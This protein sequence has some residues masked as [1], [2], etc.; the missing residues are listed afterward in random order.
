MKDSEVYTPAEDFDS[1]RDPVLFGPL[2]W[3]QRQVRPFTTRELA[4]ACHVHP[5]T[6]RK[7]FRSEPGV[8]ILGHGRLRIPYHV[9]RRVIERLVGGG[10][11]AA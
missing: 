11:A 7:W 5:A 8:L 6:I 1:R 4:Q 2:V 3:D 9:A 10:P